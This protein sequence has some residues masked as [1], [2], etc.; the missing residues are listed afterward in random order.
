L[1]GFSKLPEEVQKEYCLPV[2]V[3]QNYGK[4]QE[5]KTFVEINSKQQRIDRNLIYLLKEGFE[6]QEGTREFKEKI[7]VQVAREL[8]QTYFKDRI[9]FGTADEQKSQK[10]TL[11]ALVSSLIQ[12]NIVRNTV[13]ATIKDVV[14]I[15]SNA[16]LHMHEHILGKS[17]YFATN[18]GINVLFKLIYLLRRNVS[19]GTVKVSEEDFFKDLV[20]IFDVN[21][22]KDLKQFYGLGG[23][24]IAAKHLLLELMKSNLG[25]YGALVVD[26]RELPKSL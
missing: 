3:L 20:T 7:V 23:S 15:I 25:R 5:V 11:S 17:A 16:Q 12:N 6:W 18:Q 21:A 19:A 26:L 13:E 10:I 2:I 9:F 8:N 1:L 22:M 24:A 14:S 4:R